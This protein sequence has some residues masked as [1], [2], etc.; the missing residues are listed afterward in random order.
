[1]IIPDIDSVDFGSGCGLVVVLVFKTSGWLRRVSS[2]G[3]DS[4]PF[5]PIFLLIKQAK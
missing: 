2:G 3:F 5:P 1:M 4:H